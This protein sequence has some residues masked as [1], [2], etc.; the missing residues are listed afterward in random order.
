ML[1]PHDEAPCWRCLEVL[2]CCALITNRSDLFPRSRLKFSTKNIPFMNGSDIRPSVLFSCDQT[3]TVSNPLLIFHF[4]GA[5]T[6]MTSS[7]LLFKVFNRMSL[8]DLE[9]FVTEQEKLAS[10][11]EPGREDGLGVRKYKHSPEPG[12]NTA[13]SHTSIISA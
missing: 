1:Y 3:S 10:R 7:S 9:A 2:H 5:V 8:G 13:R 12:K 4:G 6:A 11:S